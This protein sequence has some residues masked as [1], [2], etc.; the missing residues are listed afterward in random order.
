MNRIFERFSARIAFL[1]GQPH[2]FIL[3]CCV[4]VIWGVTGPLF[5]W[6]DTWQL[7]I[8]TGT[9]IVRFSWFS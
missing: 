6:S 4:I 9:T 2:A 8:N 3:A 7:V 5:Q 1:A